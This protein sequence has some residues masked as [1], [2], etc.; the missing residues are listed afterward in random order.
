VVATAAVTARRCPADGGE[1]AAEERVV[2]T[3]RRLAEDA[4]R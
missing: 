3:R 2:A 1:A 4:S